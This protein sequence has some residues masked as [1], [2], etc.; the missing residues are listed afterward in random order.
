MKGHARQNTFRRPTYLLCRAACMCCDLLSTAFQKE[1]LVHA[2][3]F[4][5][6]ITNIMVGLVDKTALLLYYI[7][8]MIL[9]M[10]M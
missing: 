6:S 4:Y 8:Y 3:I 10:W 7:G 2:I 9:F 5:Q 1:T